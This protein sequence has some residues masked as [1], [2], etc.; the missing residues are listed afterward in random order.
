MVSEIFQ[1]FWEVGDLSILNKWNNKFLNQDLRHITPPSPPPYKR[2]TLY[3]VESW[4]V[5]S[6]KFVNKL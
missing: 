4:T 2:G 3:R 6:H 5:F 1:D